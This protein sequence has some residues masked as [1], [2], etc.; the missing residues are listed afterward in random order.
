[1]PFSAVTTVTNMTRDFGYAVIDVEVS[2]N[3]DPDRIA[4]VLRG[5]GRE[6][7]AEPRWDTVIRDDLEVMGVDRFLA[8]TLVVRARMRTTPAQRWAVSRE[9]NLRIKHRFDELAIESP[10]TSYKVLP[11]PLPAAPAPVVTSAAG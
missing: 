5:I 10:M 2:V 1:V 3:E 7:R 11:R 9:F 8:T 4:E 6:L